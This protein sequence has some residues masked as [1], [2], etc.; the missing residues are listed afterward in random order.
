MNIQPLTHEIEF[1]VRYAETDA[2]GFVHHSNYFTY[3]E[4]GRTE[5]FRAQGGDYRRMEERGHFLVVVSIACRFKA[6]A[7]YDDPLNLRTTLSKV[8]AAKLEHRYE[9]LRNDQLLTTAESVLACVDRA[10][11]VQRLPDVLPGLFGE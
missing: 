9:L 3:F 4:M 7:R 6:P 11:N 5:L 10:G 1:R 2:M 8:S